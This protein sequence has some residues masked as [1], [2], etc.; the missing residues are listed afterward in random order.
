MRGFLI[1]LAT[2]LCVVLST[3][4]GAQTPPSCADAIQPKAV[5]NPRI[6]LSQTQRRHGSRAAGLSVSRSAATN[7]SKALT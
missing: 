5:E 7:R 3:P 2:L 1:C 6:R 4:A